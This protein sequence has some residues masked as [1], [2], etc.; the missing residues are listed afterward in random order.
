MSNLLGALLALFVEGIGLVDI[1][2]PPRLPFDIYFCKL[3]S[4]GVTFLGGSDILTRL[5]VIVDELIY[6]VW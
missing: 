6:E 4:L 1:I 5:R 3:V 2:I